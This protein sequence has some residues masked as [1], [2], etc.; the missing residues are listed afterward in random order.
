MAGDYDGAESSARSARKI[1]AASIICGICIL[2][3]YIVVNFLLV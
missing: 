2:G 3:V 1:S